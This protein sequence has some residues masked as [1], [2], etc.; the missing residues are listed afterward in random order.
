[1]SRS[2]ARAIVLVFIFVLVFAMLLLLGL[3]VRWL[4]GADGW[5]SRG[6]DLAVAVCLVVVMSVL[7]TC[8]VY[9]LILR[10]HWR[11]RQ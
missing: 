11:R 6:D 4:S 2:L 3:G 5:P 10:P 8:C 1:M 7:G 9:D